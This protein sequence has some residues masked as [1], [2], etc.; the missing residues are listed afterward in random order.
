MW[1]LKVGPAAFA[2]V[3]GEAGMVA[4]RCGDEFINSG[5]RQASTGLPASNGTL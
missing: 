1:V 4:R 3:V 2:D 5:L